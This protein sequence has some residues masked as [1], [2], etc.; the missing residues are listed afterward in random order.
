MQSFSRTLVDVLECNAVQRISELG[1]GPA[2]DS[3]NP[4]SESR[5]CCLLQ[6]RFSS[7]QAIDRRFAPNPL[8]KPMSHLHYNNS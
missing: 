8:G 7:L 6:F 4:L 1:Y 2:A 3:L 5:H